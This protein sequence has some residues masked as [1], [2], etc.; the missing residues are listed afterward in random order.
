MRRMKS[1]TAIAVIGAMVSAMGAL[2]AAAYDPCDVNRDGTVSMQDM[3][4]LNRFMMGDFY[5][6]SLS[7]MDAN[8]N[9]IVDVAD[10]YCILAKL[11]GVTYTCQF[12][13]VI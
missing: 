9:L 1:L 10:S 4:Y 6:S 3:I 5:V 13:D 12:I 7:V 8:Q 2:P 11:T